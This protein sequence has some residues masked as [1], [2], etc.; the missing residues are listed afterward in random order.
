[1][2]PDHVHFNGSVNVADAESMIRE[3]A[4]RVPSG[5]RR[6]LDGETGS[7]SNWI[8]FQ[9]HRFLQPPSLVPVRPPS[10]PDGEYE[11]L[12][13]ADWADPAQVSWPDLGYADAYRGS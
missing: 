3:I 2:P 5:M 12:R 10:G 4:S 6:I 11:Q 1:M 9:L 13:L 7:R 8:F